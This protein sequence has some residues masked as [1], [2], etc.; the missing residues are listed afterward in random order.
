VL[1]GERRLTVG[2]MKQRALL[3]VLLLNADTTVSR[4]VLVDE[5]WGSSPPETATKALQ[6]NVS[7]Q[8]K[9]L[10]HDSIETRAPGYVLRIGDNA[11]DAAR[12]RE[13]VERASAEEAAD[14]SETLRGA[15]ALWRGRPLADVDDEVAGVARARLED[16]RVAALERRI[17]LDLQLGRHAEVVPEL[18][19]LV[20]DEPLRER[21]RARLMLALYRSGRQADALEVFREGRRLF[22]SELGLEPGPDLKR[23][24]RAILEQDP[25]LDPPSTAHRPSPSPATPPAPAGRR[26]RPRAAIAIVL[27]I[28][29]AASA[30]AAAVIGLGGSDAKPVVVVPNSIAVVDAGT[31]RVKADIAIGGRPVSIALGAGSIWV[32]DADDDTLL[33]IDPKTYRLE[34]A[35]G[36][37]GN[38]LSAVAY[39]F[40]S[41][42]VAGGNDGTVVRVDA[43]TNAP[44]GPVDLGVAG[45]GAVPQPVF[46][47]ATGGDAVWAQAGNRV[48]RIDPAT[49]RVTGSTPQSEPNGLA[50][51]AGSAWVTRIDE[52]LVRLDPHSAK[53]TGALRVSQ[54]LGFPTV[55][56]GALWLQVYLNPGRAQVWRI[57][58]GTLSQT[59]SI[60]V[61][62]PSL[63]GL[64]AGDDALWATDNV[65]GTIW[66]LEPDQ[67]SAKPLTTVPHHPIS[68]AESD[69][70]ILVGVQARRLS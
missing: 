26:R 66:R 57:D 27:G 41:V 48:V 43:E 21:R 56:A 54:Y 24:E 3:G 7:Q 58:P 22:D 32:V 67:E 25:A 63:Y 70:T 45:D 30:A 59:K 29:V 52:T 36:G 65:R 4:D 18:E 33:R 35:I 49:N 46:F 47:V 60:A 1:D 50:A 14:A 53:A 61:P 28:V 13:L 68:I 64:T 23:L 2:G 10:G 12:F 38:D 55:F 62:G 39:G 19:A 9:A 16:E 8:R 17:D 31:G 11:F 15:L 40:G 5:L 42:W 44:T 20:R 6:M 34:K 69:G 51:G 37:L